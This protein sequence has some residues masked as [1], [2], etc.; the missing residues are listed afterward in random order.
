MI[1]ILTYHTCIYSILPASL[2]LYSRPLMLYLLRKLF[3]DFS[4][5]LCCTSP[6][7]KL[8]KLRIVREVGG[9]IGETASSLP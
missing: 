6:L 3:S 4:S 1:M 5:V 2:S 8:S 9:G 7:G